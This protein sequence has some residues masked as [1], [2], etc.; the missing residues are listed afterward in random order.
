MF[1]I[2]NGTS[3]KAIFD[4]KMYNQISCLGVVTDHTDWLTI[5]VTNTAV[6]NMSLY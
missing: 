6:T 3:K 4:T 2:W 1:N 5:L